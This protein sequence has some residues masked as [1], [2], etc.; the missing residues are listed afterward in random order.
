MSANSGGSLQQAQRDGLNFVWID[1]C[2]IDRQSSAELSEA[3][4]S[5]YGW[6]QGAKYCCVYLHDVDQ[7]DWE[8][9]F[10]RMAGLGRQK[11]SGAP[12]LGCDLEALETGNLGRYSVAQKMSWAARRVTT[13]LEDGAYC[14]MGIFGVNMPLLYGEWERTFL[15][16]QEEVIKYNDDQIIFA[17][18]MGKKRFSGLLAP[19]PACFVGCANTISAQATEQREPFSMTNRGL[20]ITLKMTPWLADAYLAYLDCAEKADAER[21]VDLGIFLRR[22]PRMIHT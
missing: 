2:C 12:Y 15:R 1:G 13:L 9:P 8:N 14:L 4:N 16:V 18:S 20:S 10:P 17:W 21:S 7:D 5:M 22:L 6:Y 3:I 19:S 11:G